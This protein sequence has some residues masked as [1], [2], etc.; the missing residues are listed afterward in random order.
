MRD[1][2]GPGSEPFSLRRPSHAALAPSLCAVPSWAAAA[3]LALALAGPAAAQGE[4]QGGAKA[5][6]KPDVAKGQQ[7]AS[8]V[9]A[10]CHGADGNS[11]APVNPKLAAQHPEYLIKQLHDFKPNGDKPAM[12]PNP[13]MTAFAAQL[14][15]DDMRNVAAYYAG[16]K[17]KPAAAKNKDIVELGQRIY[18]A[19]V[20]GKGV[21]ACAGCHGP[22]G[23]GIPAQYARLAGQYAD[24]TEAQLV[25]FRQ[26]ARHNSEQMAQI[27]SRL[28]DAEIKAVADYIAGLR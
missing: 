13:I 8:Q 23:A 5:P 15:D 21:P 22:T 14:S 27:A 16:Q 4:A 9:C 28:S 25:A 12:R 24:Y 3:A 26:G 19:G 1:V 18:R 20:A 7:I 2:R 6:A 17:L 10:A 11:T